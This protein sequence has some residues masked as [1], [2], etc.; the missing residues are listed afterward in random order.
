MLV[1]AVVR[2]RLA[3]APLERDEGEYAYAGQLILQGIAP[4]KLAYNMKFPGTYY[5]YSLILALFGETARAIHIGLLV[6]DAA[7]TVVI[8]F[9]GRRLLGAFGGAV[10]AAAFA[11]LSV[12]R[13]TL[14]VFAHAT[15]FVLLPA[16]GGLWL[17]LRACETER[18]VDLL[19]A[20]LLLG[21]AVI[22]SQQGA[23]F[24]TVGLGFL[25]W[26]ELRT[27]GRQPSRVAIRGMLLAAGS[28][29]PFVALCAALAFE[30]V[31]GRFWFWTFQYA[32]NYVS[33]I[34]V[35]AAWP[36][37][38]NGLRTVAL[39]DE[40]LWMLG[41]IGLVLLWLVR[42]TAEVR[43]FLSGLVVAS[44]LAVSP[45]FY[46]RSHYFVLLLPAVALLAG[47]AVVSI[48]RLLERVVPAS[49]AQAI[50]AVAFGA[51]IAAYVVREQDYLFFV[52]PREVSK[53][54]FGANPFVDAPDIGRYIRDRT[55]A[56]DRIA[57]LGS[58][59]EIYF[60]AN[61]KSA[62]GYIYTYALVEQQPF[63]R[64]MQDEMIREVESAHPA[65]VVYVAIRTSWLASDYADRIFT[66]ADRY[67]QKCYDLVG[68]GEIHSSSESVLK[69]DAEATAYV[70][71]SNLLVYTYRR[72]SAAPCAAA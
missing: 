57:V 71:R 65:Y 58:E 69:W 37:F 24:V 66:W 32:K 29:V 55:T 47:V 39:P 62:T 17:V 21:V 36:L 6:V 64:R 2:L 22:M 43:V 51:V 12:D 20:G 18:A 16:L 31:L 46:F 27:L 15:H 41:A 4:Y 1:V 53:R 35:S 60:H 38:A 54:I 30:G 25:L 11:F 8:F 28:V 59:P 56:Q 40:P 45:G 67:T 33:E 48:G 61:R 52:A 26:K 50:P 49:A 63:A 72:K 42:W 34:P 9:L 7:T 3:D 23:A 14:G 13:G 70:P 10:A 5:A 44:L 19:V 68:V